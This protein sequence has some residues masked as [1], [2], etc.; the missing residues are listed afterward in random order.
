M[1]AIIESGGE[2]LS[3]Q[4]NVRLSPQLKQD[5]DRVAS[6]RHITV[7]SLLRAAIEILIGESHT[8]V[9]RRPEASLWS[10]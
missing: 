10:D 6:E 5:L 9:I 2:R 3:T 4:I 7:S 8:G 1:N